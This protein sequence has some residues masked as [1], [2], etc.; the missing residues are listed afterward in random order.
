M[1][2]S[3][4]LVYIILHIPATQLPVPYLTT[5][6]ELQTRKWLYYLKYNIDLYIY[7]SST[8]TLIN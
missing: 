3:S 6:L 8:T 7:S 2:I 1:E 4:T 5:S